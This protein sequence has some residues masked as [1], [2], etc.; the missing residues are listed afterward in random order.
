MKEELWAALPGT[1]QREVA[2]LQRA[3]A[4]VLTSFVR[5]EEMDGLPETISIED[6]V[7]IVES[8]SSPR[9]GAALERIDSLTL[10][11]D[12][13]DEDPNQLAYTR[14]R[15][16]SSV[17]SVLLPS[18]RYSDTSSQV[19]ST[20]SRRSSNSSSSSPTLMSPTIVVD[21]WTLKCISGHTT[22]SGVSSRSP[23]FTSLATPVPLPPT[24][25]PGQLRPLSSRRTSQIESD[26]F[27]ALHTPCLRPNIN[28]AVPDLPSSPTA[29]YYRAELAFLR[30][31]ALVRLRH[32]ARRIEIECLD[33]QR[34]QLGLASHNA[35]ECEMGAEGLSALE[36]WWT[37]KKE[38]VGLLE[39]RCASLM[40]ALAGSVEEDDDP[41]VG[42]DGR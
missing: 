4:A 23:S 24:Y 20:G 38:I 8:M 29:R 17:S 25:S 9:D 15:L 33:L 22:P 14:N 16:R 37:S 18:R 28:G 26:Y 2:K 35:G 3:G 7:R 30:S 31:D 40:E 39:A 11:E 6:E 13:P 21:P 32:A 27:Y 5:L 42:F 12:K 36:S 10:D 34:M 41:R 19:E 1:L